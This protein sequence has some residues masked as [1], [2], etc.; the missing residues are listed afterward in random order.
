MR[1]RFSSSPLARAPSGKGAFPRWAQAARTGPR[2]EAGP[3]APGVTPGDKG[4]DPGWF[5]WVW[6]GLSSPLATS[7]VQPAASRPRRPVRGR[8][9]VAIV[10]APKTKRAG[11]WEEGGGAADARALG[12]RNVPRTRTV[13]RA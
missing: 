13:A 6:P 8:D 10:R 2:G 12:A 7:R 11:R 3:R 5:V 1:G 9:N 4:G